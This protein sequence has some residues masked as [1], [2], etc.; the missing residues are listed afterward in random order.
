MCVANALLNIINY[1]PGYAV[2]LQIQ[3]LQILMRVCVCVCVWLCVCVWACVSVCKAQVYRSLLGKVQGLGF[4]VASLG[5]V[6]PPD[7]A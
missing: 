1:T 4:T 7:G 2:L 6:R 3:W 5:N